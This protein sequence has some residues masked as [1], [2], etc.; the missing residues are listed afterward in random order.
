MNEGRDDTDND[1]VNAE[2]LQG[3]RVESIW[4]EQVVRCETWH[5]DQ[6]GRIWVVRWPVENGLIQRPAAL[7]CA[8]CDAEPVH[9]GRA[10]RF[11]R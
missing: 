1:G 7:Q 8:G 6:F 3:P 11:G 10:L 9:V 2:A 5:C 4:Y